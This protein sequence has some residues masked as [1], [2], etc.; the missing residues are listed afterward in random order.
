MLF[1]RST[2]LVPAA[3]SAPGNASRRR[4]ASRLTFFRVPFQVLVTDSV[5]EW[6]R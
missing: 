4:A 2:A 1:D 3:E 6:A 5:E